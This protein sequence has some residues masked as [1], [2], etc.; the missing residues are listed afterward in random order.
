ME[1][2]PAGQDNQSLTVRLLAG[3]RSCT[4][5]YPIFPDLRYN[6]YVA[7]TP[8]RSPR[9]TLLNWPVRLPAFSRLPNF[10]LPALIEWTHVVVD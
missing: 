7:A 2:S 10:T 5:S 3:Q 6:Q 1:N 8:K 9:R 4:F